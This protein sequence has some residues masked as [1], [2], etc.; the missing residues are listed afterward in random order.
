MGAGGRR[1]WGD[2]A[3]ISRE[4]VTSLERKGATLGPF[5]SP[6][7]TQLLSTLKTEGSLWGVRVAMQK[8][9]CQLFV[10]AWAN[11]A[12]QDGWDQQSARPFLGSVLEI[13]LS[14]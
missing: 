13:T 2:W 9:I 14:C 8:V 6:L 12:N 5:F 3:D 10:D 4:R 1:H 11:A 7:I